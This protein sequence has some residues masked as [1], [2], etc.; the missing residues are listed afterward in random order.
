MGFWNNKFFSGESI[1]FERRKWFLEPCWSQYSN[2]KMQKHIG[3]KK[4]I[5]RRTNEFVIQ[6][7]SE[8]ED[9]NSILKVEISM[10]SENIKHAI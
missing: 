3:C 6:R 9:E 4:N 1:P 2:S 10:N 8:W 7:S 5:R